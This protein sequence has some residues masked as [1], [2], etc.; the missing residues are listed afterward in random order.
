MIIL[1]YLLGRVF[2][3]DGV[4]NM[5]DWIKNFD[6]FLFDFDGLLVNT[7]HIHFLAYKTMCLKYQIELKWDFLT[8]CKYAH[9]DK[10]LLKEEVYKKYIA[11][12]NKEPDWP[13]LYKETKELYENLLDRN[14][15]SF[16]PGAESLLLSLIDNNKKVCVV[17]NSSK[18]QVNKIKE[19]LK[20]L[21][22]IQ[23]WITRDDKVKPKPSPEGYLLAKER[24]YNENDKII[25][26]EDTIKGIR[27]LEFLDATRILIC[28]PKHPQLE[29]M[30]GD[31]CLYYESLENVFN[32]SLL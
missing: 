27:A 24:L 3:N 25:G 5:N 8:Y 19:N 9:S 31:N 2:Q 14:N 10:P 15:V 16:M 32:E 20:V 30:K 6:L 4:K 17:T 29:D 7:E 18:N 21:S 11:I 28:D 13:Y 12:Y 26:F 23:H 1:K 22:L